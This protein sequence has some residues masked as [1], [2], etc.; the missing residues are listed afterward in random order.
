[1]SGQLSPAGGEGLNQA[2][3]APSISFFFFFLPALASGAV[4]HSASETQVMGSVNLAQ[5][6][7]ICSGKLHRVVERTHAW[8]QSPR[9]A[10]YLFHNSCDLELLVVVV[11]AGVTW[12]IW[13]SVF[14]SV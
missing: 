3:L 6:P 12:I 4:Q 13:A 5:S 7:I 9:S 11:E 8:R 1:M 10:W 14:S 2:F